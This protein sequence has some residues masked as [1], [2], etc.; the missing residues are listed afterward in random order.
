[1]WWS[2]LDV[3]ALVVVTAF[4]EES[5]VHDIVNV[6]LIQKWVAVLD[7]LAWRQFKSH[8]NLPLT[9]RL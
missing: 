4:T 3:V 8:G 1:V 5:V 7:M 9:R 2:Y 6:E